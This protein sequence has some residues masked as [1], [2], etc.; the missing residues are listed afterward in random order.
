MLNIECTTKKYLTPAKYMC[1]ST[2]HVTLSI[3]P[4]TAFKRNTHTH[5]YS[6]PI[7]RTPLQEKVQQDDIGFKK[8]T[9]NENI[10]K[11]VKR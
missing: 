8:K 9:Q 7:I 11:E 10:L 4:E 5:A 6:C 3:A 2:Q 1:T